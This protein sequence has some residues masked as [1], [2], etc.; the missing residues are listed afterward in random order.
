MI[1]YVDTSAVGK[2]IVEEPE[3]TALADYL[4]EISAN[5]GVIIVSSSLLETELRRL[6]DRVGI[7]QLAVTDVLKRFALVDIERGSFRE[8]GL[9]LPGSALRSLD[10]LHI[11]VAVRIAAD[12]FITYDLRQAEAA[13]SV[14]LTV[15]RP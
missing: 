6:A 5:D 15:V 1:V 10:A 13:Q 7:S 3:S 2:L 11:A 12:E 9:I 4:D 8:A 14:G